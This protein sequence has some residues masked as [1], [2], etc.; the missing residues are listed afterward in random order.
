MPNFV[1]IGLSIA[2]IWRFLDFQ[3][4]GCPPSCIFK[5]FKILSFIRIRKP[6]V[7]HHIKFGEDRPNAC[8]DMTIWSFQNG[9][10]R[11]SWILKKVKFLMV[12]LLQVANIWLCAKFRENRPSRCWDIAIFRFSL[13][14]P[15]AIL[16][17]QKVQN[18]IIYSK[19]EAENAS[20]C[21]IL[22]R[23]A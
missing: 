11:P 7:T 8:R 22:W 13:W 2:E 1:K 10:R 4:G 14:R 6:K 23:S 12:D 17:F 9:G 15:S 21:Q 16:D 5:K 3:D 20:S 19:P 18:F